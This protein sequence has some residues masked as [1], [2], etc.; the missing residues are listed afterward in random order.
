MSPRSVPKKDV[1]AISLSPLERQGG[2]EFDDV[3]KDDRW[4]RTSRVDLGRGSIGLYC[5]YFRGRAGSSLNR[6]AFAL[7]R[8][9]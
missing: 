2:L 3:V 6:T 9:S 1:V 8:Y 7:E 5:S 4:C